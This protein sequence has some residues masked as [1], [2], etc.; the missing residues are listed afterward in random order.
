MKILKHRIWN[1]DLGGFEYR[2]PTDGDFAKGCQ[3]QIYIGLQ[4]SEG[5]EVWEGD[6]LDN[7]AYKFVIEWGLDNYEHPQY[8]VPGFVARL[9]PGDGLQMSPLAP[10]VAPIGHFSG[11]KEARVVG[12]IC[13]T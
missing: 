8:Q 3:I 10:I 4:D 7:G 11:I 13:Q 5:V 12:N 6:I 1:G 2:L 9:L